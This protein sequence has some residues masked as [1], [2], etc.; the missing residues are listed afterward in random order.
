MLGKFPKHL[1]REQ[2]EE[3]FISTVFVNNSKIQ[4]FKENNSR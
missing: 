3:F 1:V 2:S 4:D